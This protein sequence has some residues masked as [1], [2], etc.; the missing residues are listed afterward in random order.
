[1]NND[2]DNLYL[3]AEWRNKMEN[4]NEIRS[5]IHEI[6]LLKNQRSITEYSLYSDTKFED[7]IKSKYRE[8]K[9]KL[10]QR[11]LNIATA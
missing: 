4:R 7:I 5:C 11:K 2:T 8:L 1:M 6:R 3:N 10:N 9:N